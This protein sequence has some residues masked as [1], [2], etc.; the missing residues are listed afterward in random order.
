MAN[1]LVIDWF[2]GLETTFESEAR[3]AGLLGHG[4]TIGQ[5][6]EFLI[7]RLLKTI[8]PTACTSA[9]AT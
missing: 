3:L 5:A 8:L 7:A 2:D 9:P 4:S 6:R 1:K